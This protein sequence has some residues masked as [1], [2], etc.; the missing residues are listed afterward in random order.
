ML[1]GS[2]IEMVLLSS[3]SDWRQVSGWATALSNMEVTS[4][5]N[6]RLAMMLPP[7]GTPIK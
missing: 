4:L 1:G 5:R 6:Q 7:R 2:H 3:I